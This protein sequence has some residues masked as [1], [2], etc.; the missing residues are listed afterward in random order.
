MS[1]PH[2]TIDRTA[3]EPTPTLTDGRWLAT[4]RETPAPSR[5]VQQQFSPGRETRL[6]NLVDEENRALLD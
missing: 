4:S 2:P 6:Y 3:S 1:T 5:R